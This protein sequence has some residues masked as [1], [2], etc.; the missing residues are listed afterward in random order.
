MRT[1]E[2]RRGWFDFLVSGLGTAAFATL[3]SQDGKG[4]IMAGGRETASPTVRAKRAIH[5]CL[6]GGYSQ[7]DSFDYKPALEKY[8]GKSIPGDAMP[9]TF[10]GSGGLLCK[11]YWPFHQ[12][13]ASG[14]WVSDLFPNLANVVDYM[15]IIRSMVADSANHTPAF[16]QQ[17]SGFLTNGFP[18]LG[19]WLSF[20]LG[21]ITDTLPTFVVLP[22][23]RSLPNG[24]AS[25]WGSGF[26]PAEHQ[27]VML[28]G[29]SQPIRNLFAGS[30]I[31][32]R[33]DRD[34]FQMLEALNHRHL[35]GREAND[36][37]VARLR[38]YQLAAQMQ[39][40]IPEVLDFAD[41]TAATLQLYGT[42]HEA[43][44][45]CGRRC[46]LARRLLERGVRFVQI[47][48]GGCFGGE[49]RHGW[50][51]HE[52]CQRDH[53]RE[54]ERIDRP[55]AGLIQDLHQRGMLEDTLVVFTTE[56]GRTP[57]AN[58]P[59]GQVNLGRDH[60][61]EGF[62]VWMAGGGL[63]RGFA[64][65]ETDELG[66][67]AMSD[68][69]SWPDFH[70]TLLHLLGIDHEQLTFYHNG[71]QRRLTNVHGQVLHQLLA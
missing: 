51:S 23:R 24:G 55:V 63:R 66:W 37:L 21:K 18:S 22:D 20:G 7:V 46:L 6:I 69:V 10:F 60:N 54:A 61:P 11:S 43:T 28:G 9:E 48:S 17:Q 14:L 41:E 12:R 71:I 57:F 40:S 52:D 42:Q 27:G 29:G 5:I 64:F 31:D 36:L 44:A 47:F 38:S 59:P 13:G 34:S 3:A 49:P 68:K 35:E 58:A 53:A 45:D 50:D 30:D 32:A 4:R 39:V 65:G 25:N 62:T 56:F 70:A 16:L 67:K 8:H 26:L 19:S 2:N 15:T 33:A 1:H